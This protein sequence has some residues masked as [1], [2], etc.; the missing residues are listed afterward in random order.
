MSRFALPLAVVGIAACSASERNL[1]ASDAAPD[2][3]GGSAAGGGMGASAGFGG[4]ALDASVDV[5]DASA[6]VDSGVPT[7]PPCTCTYKQSQQCAP[8]DPELCPPSKSFCCS[9]PVKCSAMT[10]CESHGYVA[11]NWW[12]CC[13]SASH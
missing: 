1:S 10:G 13:S 9:C 4:G 5:A 8:A 11:S 12:W 3:G 2:G 7:C 6:D